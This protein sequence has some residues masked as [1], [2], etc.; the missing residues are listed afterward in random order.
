MTMRKA[1]PIAFLSLLAVLASALAAP[2]PGADADGDDD[3][4]PARTAPPPSFGGQ[5][6]GPLL[7]LSPARQRQ[8][9]L[10]TL[11]LAGF[12]QARATPAYGHV[13][14][15]SPLLD[16]RARYRSAQSELSIAEASTRLSQQNHE[17]V[18][19]LHAESIIATRDL[20]Q[21]E[22]QLAADRAR[23]DA[24]ARHMREVREEALQSFGEE[25][26]KQAVEADSKLFDGLLKHALVLALVALPADLALPKTLR[27]VKLSPVGDSATARP[28]RLVSAAPKTEESTQ[29]ETWFFVAD[30]QG[31]RSG[32]RLDAWIPQ[33]GAQAAGV[34]IPQ[35]AVVWRDGQAWV[36]VKSGADGFARRPV[37]AHQTHGA[38]WFVAAGFAPG[39]QVVAVGGQMLLSEEQRG[40][41]PKEGDED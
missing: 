20:L 1:R 37:G 34:L 14:D 28:A 27:S 39:E 26:F 40:Q 23:Q 35:S 32:M 25:L 29:G 5:A 16:L 13:L 19:K 11:A 15:I 7:S 36:Y 30:A 21:A 38:D 18:S 3:A 10:K 6:L 12:S 9:G 41:L 4:R 22:A 24:A 31:L 33:Q 8:G 2:G 17:R